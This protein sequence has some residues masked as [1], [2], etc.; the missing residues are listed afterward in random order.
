MMESQ[1]RF[2]VK[3]QGLWIHPLY[4]FLDRGSGEL[5]TPSREPVRPVLLVD[6]SRLCSFIFIEALFVCVCS[7]LV[8][9]KW[10]FSRLME[11]EIEV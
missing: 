1:S 10:C 5:R 4:G 6:T 8:M 9:R 11:E 2:N 3:D 7:I